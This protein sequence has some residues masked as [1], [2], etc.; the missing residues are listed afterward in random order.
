MNNIDISKRNIGV[1]FTNEEA[2][3]MVWAPLIQS[4]DI[5]FKHE[6][7]ALEPL[8]Y[9][10]WQIKTKKL[11]PNDRYNFIINR[12]KKLPDPASLYQPEG[13]HGPSQAYDLKAFKWTDTHWKTLPLHEYIIYE[14]H[15]GT[16]TETGTFG[17]IESK[18]DYLKSLGINAIELMPIAQFPGNR[19]WGYDGVFPFAAQNTYGGPERLQHLVNS[20]HQKGI[21]VI[22]DVV[23]NHLGPE[24][25]YLGAYAPY[26]TDKYKTPWGNAINFGD[27]W[28]DGVRQYFIE[29]ALMWLRDFHIDALRFDA[30]HAIIDL[31]P[32]HILREIKQMVNQL[33]QQ[34]GRTYHL[35]VEVDRN[36]CRYIN[37]LKDQGYGMDAQWLDEFHHA[38]RVVA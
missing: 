8:D 18:L 10:Y 21:S 23:Y 3:I 13:V 33:M 24:G 16:F 22:L 28:C 37:P 9:G 36:D 1:N 17:A 4:I 30:V 34:T 20:C 29:N 35:I 15:T 27:A 38:L 2:E 26:F 25:N 19:N 12:E 6:H 11:K 32:V 31:S 5:Q 7:I 14:L